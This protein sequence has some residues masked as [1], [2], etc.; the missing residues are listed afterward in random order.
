MKIVAH[1][2]P[3]LD[4]TL[5]QLQGTDLRITCIPDM[6]ANWPVKALLGSLSDDELQEAAQQAPAGSMDVEKG[7]I[8][9][10]FNIYLIETPDY[11]ALID[12]GVGNQKIRADRPAWHQRNSAFLD[13]LAALGVQP[14]DVDYL[15]NTHLHADHVGWNTVFLDGKWQAA[16]P[17]AAYI[18]PE[19]ELTYWSQ[20]HV[21]NAE[22]TTLHGAFEDSIKPII[23][24]I[25]FQ[26]VP[27]NYQICDGLTFEPAF[28]HSPGMVVVRLKSAE[29][30]VL[31]TADVIHHP[32]QLSQP[33]AV[34]NFCKAPDQARETRMSLLENAAK[35]RVI[36][37]PYHFPLPV[38]G[39]VEGGEGIYSYVPFDVEITTKD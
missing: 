37:A 34:S 1:Y 27:A 14:D 20:I 18:V 15:I 35:E 30:N 13:I 23:E 21:E 4:A 7:T 5:H 11:V 39:Q 6:E 19:G 32:L 33:L 36:M 28:G 26:A 10:N 8:R 38:F 3:E 17:N 29:L 25:G 22:K 12:A 2:L 24:T 9:L 31:F 16:F